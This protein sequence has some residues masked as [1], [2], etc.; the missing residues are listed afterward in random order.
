MTTHLTLFLAAS[1]VLAVTPG[2]GL[3]YVAARTLAGG[4]RDGLLSIAGTVVGGMVHVVAGALGVSAL[5]L[6]SARIFTA[7]QFAGAIYLVWLGIRTLLAAGNEQP[8]YVPP[9]R[10]AFRDGVAVEAFNPKTAVFFL[11]FIPQFI[12]PAHS[13]AWQF[14]LLGSMAVTLNS[15]ADIAVALAASRARA[16][17]RQRPRL[18]RRLGQFSGAV[19]CGLGISLLFA[20]RG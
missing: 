10:R 12:E 3:F 7:L 19:L 6:A 17:Y 11:A 13:V 15:L 9:H 16:S 4:R 8:Q 20:R 5:L 2:P 1:A 14:V 18:M